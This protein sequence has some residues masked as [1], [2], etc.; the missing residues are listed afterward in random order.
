MSFQQCRFNFGRDPFRFPP[1]DR[2]FKTF[3]EFGTLS[4]EERIV[5]PRCG[6]GWMRGQEGCAAV[7]TLQMSRYLRTVRY[8]ALLSVCCVIRVH[9]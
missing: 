5:L 6:T 8:S 3:N 4:E 1:T 9:L 2:P 7:V